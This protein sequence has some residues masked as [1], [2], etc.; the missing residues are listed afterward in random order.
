MIS[1]SKAEEYI[2]TN[3]PQ[4]RIIRHETNQSFGMV[5]AEDIYAPYASP[6]FTNSAMDGFAVKWDD[7]KGASE[8]NPVRLTIIGESQAGIPFLKKLKEG[9]AIRINTGAKIPAGSDTVIPIEDCHDKTSS[10]EILKVKGKNQAIR[11]EGEEFVKGSLLLKK[12]SLIQG[13]HLALLASMGIPTIHVI[14]KPPLSLIVTGT[15]LVGDGRNKKDFQVYDINTPMLSSLIIESGGRVT[16]AK[17]IPDNIDY[18]IDA[19]KNATDIADLIVISG[20][21][22]VGPHDVVKKAAEICGFKR[23]FWKVNQKPGKPFFFARKNDKLLFGLPGNPVSAYMGF[24]HYIKPVI[25]KLCGKSGE[26]KQIKMILGHDYVVKG[27]RA[28]FLRISIKDGLAH[29]LSQQGSHMLTS[30]SLA[31]GYFIADGNAQLDKGMPL[32][33][34]LFPDRSF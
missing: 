10:L 27:E 16:S 33:V 23:I 8:K 11:F 31:D 32:D 14:A 24:F 26:R 30:I 19:I 29:I 28:E 18:T 13:R 7:V 15:E 1:I 9:E 34:Y 22:S 21:V 20:G 25:A 6:G 3:I 12:G 17:R 5:L 2:S 4:P